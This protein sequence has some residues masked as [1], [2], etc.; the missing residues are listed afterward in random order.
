M[1]QYK[2]I[3]SWLEYESSFSDED[4]EKAQALRLASHLNLAM[5]HLKLQ[6]FSA[7]IENCNKERLLRRVRAVCPGRAGCAPGVP[8]TWPW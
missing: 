6:A 5:C 2:K 3:V 4:A 1:L 7:A 8:E